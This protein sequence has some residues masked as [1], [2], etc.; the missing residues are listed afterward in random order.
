MVSG[1]DRP[2]KVNLEMMARPVSAD[3][4]M[5]DFLD[6]LPDVLK[7]KELRE[8]IAAIREDLPDRNSWDRVEPWLTVFEN[9]EGILRCAH[10]FKEEAMELLASIRT[11]GR[12]KIPVTVET[13]GT[14]GTIKRAKKKYLN[15]LLGK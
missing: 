9:N 4:L 7:V 6:S 13:L 8:F 11:I 12:E 10:G 14:S 2:S 15:N 3:A 1:K 5:S